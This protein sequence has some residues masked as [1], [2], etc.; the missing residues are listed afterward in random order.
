MNKTLFGTPITKLGMRV[1]TYNAFKAVYEGE[2]KDKGL[3][4]VLESMEWIS[5][6]RV[7]KYRGIG[8][9]R[10]EEMEAVMEKHGLHFKD[11]QPKTKELP[12]TKVTLKIKETP[13][14]KD[15]AKP[16]KGLADLEN[17][18]TG[19]KNINGSDHIEDR[20]NKMARVYAHDMDIM[21]NKIKQLWGAIKTLEKEIA[22]TK[23]N[24]HVPQH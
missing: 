21:K 22:D 10:I 14:V 11:R 8:K 2:F 19:G 18:L 5:I 20:L 17:I 9:T 13:P 23:T 1:L 4:F 6:E 7:R 12:L 24:S 16:S 15:V 3:P